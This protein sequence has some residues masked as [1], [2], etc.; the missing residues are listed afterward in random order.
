MDSKSGR[1]AI[2]IQRVLMATD[3]SEGSS[4][5]LQHALAVAR[6][7]GASFDLLHVIQLNAYTLSGPGAMVQAHALAEREIEALT[8]S[9]Q[10]TGALDGVNTHS[11]VL[12][13]E[14]AEVVCRLV[15]CHKTDLVA[16]GTHGRSGIRKLVLGSVAEEVF[17]HAPC[18][19]LTVGPYSPGMQQEPSL[20]HALVATDLSPASTEALPWAVAAAQEFGARL[21]MLHVCPDLKAKGEAVH[22]WERRTEGLQSRLRDLVRDSAFPVPDLHFAVAAGTAADEI[23]KFASA[24]KVDLIILGLKPARAFSDRVP[25]L[26]AYRI[27]CEAACPVLTVRGKE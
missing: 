27:V 1:S 9:L 25:W 20:T 5:A 8:A 21:T 13:G 16:V 23:V 26:H 22:D 6:H 24:Q 14:V 11:W 19:V 10:R 12:D 7:Y 17:R 15:G 3:L 2:S 4:R 18:P